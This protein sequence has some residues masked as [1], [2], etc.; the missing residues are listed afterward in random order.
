MDSPFFLPGHPPC[1]I[2]SSSMPT[3]CYSNNI[4]GTITPFSLTIPSIESPCSCLSD[5]IWV[6]LVLLH[7]CTTICCLVCV[8][9]FYFI[10]AI[11]HELWHDFLLH[12]VHSIALDL[13]FLTISWLQQAPTMLTNHVD[14]LNHPPHCHCPPTPIHIPYSATSLPYPY[15]PTATPH[16][17][18]NWCGVQSSG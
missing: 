14:R 16:L 15:P 17:S 2:S 6:Y 1:L 11:S 10:L 7:G 9:T 4:S 13:A 18:A 8:C 5:N 12:C 3:L